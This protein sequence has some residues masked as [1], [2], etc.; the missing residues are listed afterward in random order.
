MIFFR[1]ACL[2]GVDE[3]VFD[4]NGIVIINF[5]FLVFR[6]TKKEKI[7]LRQRA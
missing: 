4:N 2:S 7:F 1:I 6:K 3:D 5:N